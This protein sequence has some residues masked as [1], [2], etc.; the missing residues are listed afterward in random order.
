MNGTDEKAAKEVRRKQKE[1][2]ARRPFQ[3]CGIS[4][5]EHQTKDKRDLK[6]H[7]AAVH[8]VG[9]VN[10]VNELR[11]ELMADITRAT[12]EQRETSAE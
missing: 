1:S 7:Q 8:G 11:A 5:C 9:A 2:K 10:A 12:R 6:Y 3:V 4:G